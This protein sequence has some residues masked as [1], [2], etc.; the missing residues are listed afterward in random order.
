[1]NNNRLDIETYIRLMKTGDVEKVEEAYNNYKEAKKHCV[2]FMDDLKEGLLN[3]NKICIEAGMDSPFLF[4]YE[5]LDN[6]LE[7][8]MKN[9]KSLENE[10][11]KA[12]ANYFNILD[13][14]IQNSAGLLYDD[15][16][17]DK[18]ARTEQAKI[19]F[20]ESNRKFEDAWYKYREAEAKKNV[21]SKEEFNAKC[22]S[23]EY[24]K[25]MFLSNRESLLN[26]KVLDE[27]T[28][29][30]LKTQIFSVETTISSLESKQEVIKNAEKVIAEVSKETGIEI[31]YDGGKVA[32]VKDVKTEEIVNKEDIKKEEVKTEPVVETEKNVEEN[33]E[34][35]KKEEEN[36]E[37]V[38]EPEKAVKVEEKVENKQNVEVKDDSKVPFGQRFKVTNARMAKAAPFIK[39]TLLMTAI[40]GICLTSWGLGTLALGAGVG[41]GFQSMYKTLLNNGSPR[42]PALDDPKFIEKK[43]DSTWMMGT[44]Y[45]VKTQFIKAWKNVKTKAV[46]KQEP[47]VEEQQLEDSLD[48][49]NASVEQAMGGR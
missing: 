4:N 9:I 24:L 2:P 11:S 17:K 39:S 1:M 44:I 20:E 14:D 5:D 33:V 6:D 3:V 25:E 49:L 35:I 43:D 36:L 46:V 32:E 23:F 28:M 19:A 8:K 38:V 7:N 10:K 45:S 40:S 16:M 37:P 34:E 27:R 31:I 21:L 30:K 18:E 42:I 22:D 12:R 26:N 13:E 29:N 48:D 47:K 15:V 41:V